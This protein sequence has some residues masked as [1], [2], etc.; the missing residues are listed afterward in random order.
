M[1]NKPMNL[2]SKHID[3][4]WEFVKDSIMTL[5]KVESEKQVADNLTKSLPKAR[6]MLARRIMSG[7]W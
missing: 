6:V 3:I 5:V 4:Q 1:D 2:R 7:Q